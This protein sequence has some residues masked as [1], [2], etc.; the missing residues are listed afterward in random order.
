MA[1]KAEKIRAWEIYMMS[2][3]IKV[4]NGVI[5]GRTITTMDIGKS[6]LDHEPLYNKLSVAIYHNNNLIH[7]PK[8]SE[9]YSYY[10]EQYQKA[11]DDFWGINAE[12]FNEPFVKRPKY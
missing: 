11:V 3:K 2:Q 12:N 4:V 6:W 8:D 10:E 5:T 9:D 1:T 7:Q